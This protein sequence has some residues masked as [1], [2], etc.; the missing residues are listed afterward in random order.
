MPANQ[1][2]LIKG[3]KASASRGVG[4][5]LADYLSEWQPDALRYTLASVLPEQSDSE[6]TEEEMIRRNNEELVAT[7]GNLV[8]RV[9]T[10]IKNNQDVISNP[11]EIQQVDENL[12]SEAEKAF[13]DIGK[14]IEAVEL[15]TALQESMRFVSKVN[16]YLNETEPWK[17][18]KEDQNRAGRILSLHYEQAYE[19]AVLYP[20]LKRY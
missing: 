15:K 4:K 2:I 10:Q 8:Q 9:F 3:Q 7:W 13:T 19:E 18:V 16:V 1:Y 17:T 11:S 12:L 6:L 5:S 14:H 20:K